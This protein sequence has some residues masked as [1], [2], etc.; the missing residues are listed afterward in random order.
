MMQSK[1]SEQVTHLDLTHRAQA[2]R[3][4]HEPY[5]RAVAQAAVQASLAIADAVDRL[6]AVLEHMELPTLTVT[7]SV[8]KGTCRIQASKS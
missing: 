8:L 6:A 7:G 2:E 4:L 3:L 1:R 5:D